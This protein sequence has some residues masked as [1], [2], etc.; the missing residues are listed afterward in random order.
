MIN[1]I[2]NP[3][4]NSMLSVLIFFIGAIILNLFYKYVLMRLAS[5]TRI[6]FDDLVL[7]ALRM[8]ILIIFFISSVYYSISDLRLQS[9]YLSHINNSLLSLCIL[10]GLFAIIRVTSIVIRNYI[11]NIAGYTGLSKQVLNLYHNI[12]KLVFI[13]AASIVICWIWKIDVTP[14]VASAGIA[15]VAVAFAAKDTISNFFGGISIFVDNPYKVGDYITLDN[16][17]RGEVIEIGVRSTRIKTRDDIMVSIPNSIIS[18]TKII[19]ESQPY[20]HF[21]TRIPLTIAYGS[22]IK[23]V[24]SLLVRLA[25]ENEYIVIEKTPHIRVRQLSENGIFLELL[26]WVK[27]PSLRGLVIHELNIRIYEE[28]QKLGIELPYPKRDITINTNIQEKL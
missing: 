20:P 1:L 19:N 17:E 27:E 13:I 14:I 9:I 11:S 28:F 22:D 5:R 12:S 10:S 16:R 6:L 21:R 2:A 25:R 7:E 4:Y 18:N 3:Y 23:F 24:E 15:S 8:P 26:C